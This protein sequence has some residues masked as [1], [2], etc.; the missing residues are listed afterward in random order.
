MVETVKP[1]TVPVRN[2]ET[3]GRAEVL[4]QEPRAAKALLNRRLKMACPPRVKTNWPIGGR[5]RWTASNSPKIPPVI[6]AGPKERAL[7]KK[8]LAKPSPM[9]I[10]RMF[11]APQPAKPPAMAPGIPPRTYPSQPPQ[12]RPALRNLMCFKNPN[13]LKRETSR[14]NPGIFP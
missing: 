8:V 4:I 6:P 13:F 2:E 11:Q 7:A 3:A 12:K 14:A 5:P 1:K 10:L 9:I